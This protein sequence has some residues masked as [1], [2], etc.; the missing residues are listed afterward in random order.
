MP[1]TKPAGLGIRSTGL[2]RI[3]PESGKGPGGSDATGRRHGGGDATRAVSRNSQPGRHAL[4]RLR[5]PLGDEMSGAARR[6][7]LQGAGDLRP[8]AAPMT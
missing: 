7:P 4:I 3:T 5:V 2:R 6:D 1:G 8:P